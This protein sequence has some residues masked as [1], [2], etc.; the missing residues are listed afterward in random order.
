MIPSLKP[1][2]VTITF[3]SGIASSI[4]F[5]IS[6]P[7]RSNKYFEPT[8]GILLRFSLDSELINDISFNNCDLSNSKL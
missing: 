4:I 1:F 7:L 5:K 3:F 6:I 8:H 2:C